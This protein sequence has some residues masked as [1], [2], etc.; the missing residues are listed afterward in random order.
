MIACEALLAGGRRNEA[1]TRIESMA[2]R[3]D[4]RAMPSAWGE[5]LRL[6]GAVHTAGDRI[7]SPG[8]LADFLFGFVHRLLRRIERGTGAGELC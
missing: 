3:I 1:E 8:R 6:R 5:F 2:A 4:A 7:A